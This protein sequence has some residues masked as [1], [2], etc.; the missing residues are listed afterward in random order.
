MIAVSIMGMLAYFFQPLYEDYHVVIKREDDYA[1]Y[2]TPSGQAYLYSRIKRYW[3]RI[4]IIFVVGCILFFWGFYMKFGERGFGMLLGIED[5]K[6]ASGYSEIDSELAEGINNDGD[7]VSE[8]GKVYINYITVKGT[9][10]FYRDQHVGDADD[11]RSFV[12]KLD[13]TNALYLVDGYASSATYNE[14][15]NILSES[16]FEYEMD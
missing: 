14:I 13:T 1:H 4:I 2:A 9:E 15:K 11:F 3:K 16:G 7:Y 12:K 6:T 10:V 8:N 5:Y